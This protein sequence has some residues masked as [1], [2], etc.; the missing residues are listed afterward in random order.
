MSSHLTISIFQNTIHRLKTR[1][2]R[3]WRSDVL[4]K[5]SAALVRSAAIEIVNG[6]GK[7][8][9]VDQTPPSFL[10]TKSI[11][12]SSALSDFP[13]ACC[14]VLKVTGERHLADWEAEKSALPHQ[15]CELKLHTHTHTA[16]QENKLLSVGLTCVFAVAILVTPGSFA[17]LSPGQK[18]GEGWQSQASRCRGGSPTLRLPRAW[19]PSI[20]FCGTN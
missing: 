7:D 4:E 2:P 17:S 20:Y 15:H 8:V 19:F 10:P 16:P 3:I 18:G 1:L 6:F 14:Q 9:L 12:P 5:Q 13:F 11:R